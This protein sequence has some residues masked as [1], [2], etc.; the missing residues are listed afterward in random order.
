MRAYAVTHPPGHAQ[1]AIEPGWHQILFTA[2][3]VLTVRSS[4]AV[5]TVPADRAVWVP[6]T[7]SATFHAARS[8]AVRS[9]Y[10]RANDFPALTAALTRDSQTMNVTAFGSTLLSEIVSRAPLTPDRDA[11]DRALV[12]LLID[13]LARWPTEPMRLPLPRSALGRSFADAALA[14]PEGSTDALAR[15]IGISRRTVER[16]FAEQTAMGLGAWRRRARILS[17]LDNLAEH[18]SVTAA[19]TGAGYATTS[20]Y[21]AAFRAELGT[22]PGRFLDTGVAD[23]RSGRR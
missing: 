3:G 8:V 6:A 12:T 19:A 22:S 5:W 4:D 10:L 2:T 1:I 9:I 11:V 16:V 23:S 18:R 15:S 21:I 17:S 14:H 20:A 7:L 13:Q